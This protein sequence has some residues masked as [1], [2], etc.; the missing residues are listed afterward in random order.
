MVWED[1]EFKPT[2]HITIKTTNGK[3]PKF[4]EVPAL[5]YLG[6]VITRRPNSNE[7]INARIMAGMRCVYALRI[8]PKGRD[9]RVGDDERWKRRTNQNVNILCGRPDIIGVVKSCTMVW[10]Y[11]EDDRRAATEKTTM[12]EMGKKDEDT[13]M[14]EKVGE[15]KIME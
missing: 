1:E 12:F 3:T 9:I 6:T 8:V 13:G 11:N 15:Q 10:A 5:T 4:E 7:E 14:E 2:G